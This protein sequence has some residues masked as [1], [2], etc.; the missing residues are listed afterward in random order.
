MVAFDEVIAFSTRCLQ[1][2]ES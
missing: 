1:R 2:N